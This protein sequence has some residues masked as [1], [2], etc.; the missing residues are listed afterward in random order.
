MKRL[1]LFPALALALTACGGGSSSSNDTSTSPTSVEGKIDAVNHTQSTISVNGRQY[2]VSALNYQGHTLETD[3]LAPEMMVALNTST[4]AQDSANVELDPTFTGKITDIS[5]STFKVNGVAL[6]FDRLSNR[7]KE[8]DWV[9]VSTL[10]TANAGYKVLSVIQFEYDANGMVEAEGRIS[11]VDFNNNSFQIGP[12]LKVWFDQNLINPSHKL[13]DGAW[14]EVFGRFNESDST[15]S[16]EKINIKAFN[17]VLGRGEVEGVVTWVANDKSRFE[18]NYRGIFDIPPSTK[19][20]DGTKNDLRPGVEIEVEYVNQAHRTIAKEIEFDDDFDFDVD[21]K[22]FEFEVEG[23]VT[24]IDAESEA[25][26]INGKTVSTDANTE[27]E[28]DLTFDSL[29]GE[30]VEVEGIIVGNKYVARE[31]ERED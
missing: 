20:E 16:A 23:Y 11:N 9:M 25:F 8:G 19:F 4:R 7:I 1:A 30:K 31:I 2:Q 14:V 5:G 27:Y 22:D 10:P 21:W 13:R 18:L 29:L 26:T 12:S 28:D 17:G 6:Q 3:V 15:L 24:D